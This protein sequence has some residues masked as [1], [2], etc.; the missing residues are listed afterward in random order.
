MTKLLHHSQTRVSLIQPSSGPR[1]DGSL[2]AKQPA[3]GSW[4]AHSHAPTPR[5]AY[6][7]NSSLLP[8]EARTC[9]SSAATST[10]MHDTRLT[11]GSM[12]GLMDWSTNTRTTPYYYSTSHGAA[13]R[14]QEVLA[15]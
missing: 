8:E 1:S 14:H 11:G 10:N 15:G 7:R 9:V 12:T 2:L 3:R 5:E 6:F 13:R 4:E